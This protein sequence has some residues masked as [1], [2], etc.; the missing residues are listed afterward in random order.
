MMKTKLIST[1]LILMI[2]ATISQSQVKTGIDVIRLMKEKYDNSY[3]QNF[4]FSQH[5]VQYKGDS[6]INKTIWHEAYR[7]PN[8]LILKFDTYD[9]GN[10]YIFKDDNIYVM[11]NNKVESKQRDIHD[12]LVLGFDVYNQPVQVT[13]DKLTEKGYDLNKVYE[14]ELNGKVVYCVGAESKK[15][16]SNCFYIDKEHLLFV[17]MIN[18]THSRYDKAVF[19]NFRLVK[20]TY[21][22]TKVVFIANGKPIMTEEYFDMDFPEKLDPKIF[23][24]ENFEHAS[25]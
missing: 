14:T 24:P 13:V 5:V 18:H 8:Q 16:A 17:K 12:L 11:K 6:I 22:A 10:G 15:D 9:S 25:W 21:L 2:M 1:L 19:E 3:I 20:G 23:D 4:T 7:S